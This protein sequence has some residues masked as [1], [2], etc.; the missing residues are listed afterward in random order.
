MGLKTCE[1]EATQNKHVK[2]KTKQTRIYGFQEMASCTLEQVCVCMN[3]ACVRRLDHAYID[4]YP[5]NLKTHKQSRTLKQQTNN[6]RKKKGGK[7]LKG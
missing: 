5:E 2:A 3:L 1:K 4:P 7:E 6:L